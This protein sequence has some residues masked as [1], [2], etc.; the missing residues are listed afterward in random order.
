MFR[1]FSQSCESCRD[2]DLG[3]G[4]LRFPAENG[5]ASK[6]LNC[7]ALVGKVLI[8]RDTG[9]EHQRFHHVSDVTLLNANQQSRT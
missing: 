9:G 5:E 7:V 1:Y 8:Q 6:V 2:S 4:G 3:S